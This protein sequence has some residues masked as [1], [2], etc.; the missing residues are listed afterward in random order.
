MAG[1]T[2]GTAQTPY[3]SQRQDQQIKTITFSGDGADATEIVAAVAG[4]QILITGG[5][6]S[7]SAATAESLSIKSGTTTLY[8]IYLSDTAGQFVM[9]SGIHTVAGEALNLD[10]SGAAQVVSGW[11][12]YKI[13]ENQEPV[14]F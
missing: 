12:E 1:L 7:W 4:K 9:N 5:W 13:V 6:L 14:L 11:L 2:V 3:D 8:T 10:K